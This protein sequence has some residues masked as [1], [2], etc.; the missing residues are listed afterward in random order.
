M[1]NITSQI[2]FDSIEQHFAFLSKQGWKGVR[3]DATPHYC[4]IEY[5]VNTMKVWVGYEFY[6]FE[7]YATLGFD[8]Y[9]GKF[10]LEEVFRLMKKQVPVCVY[11]VH[12]KDGLNNCMEKMSVTI[13][14]AVSFLLQYPSACSSL[15]KQRVR[16][17]QES[18]LKQQLKA[19]LQQVEH[20]WQTRQYAEYI[21]I[22]TPFSDHLGKTDGAR[23]E[24]AKKKLSTK[25]VEIR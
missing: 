5:A 1:R 15:E 10:Y 19:I 11:S 6:A 18:T 13:Q 3:S 12:T 17:L 16:S 4:G 22:L 25:N 7:L 20:M 24:Y 14:E 8:G 21:E 23:F 9:E 2:I